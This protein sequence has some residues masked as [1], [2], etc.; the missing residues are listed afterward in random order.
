[1]VA[2]VEPAH[3]PPEWRGVECTAC[4][5]G[6]LHLPEIMGRSIKTAD[7]IVEEGD[8]H[9]TPGSID[10]QTGYF[11]AEGVVTNDVK[12]K[13]DGKFGVVEGCEEFGKKFPAMGI[14]FNQVMLGNDGSGVAPEPTQKTP[15]SGEI[16]FSLV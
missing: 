15:G 6:T 10:Q 5:A 2:L 14:E 16:P 4:H 7:I 1:M 12:L 8:L 13:T 9:A 3:S 11:F